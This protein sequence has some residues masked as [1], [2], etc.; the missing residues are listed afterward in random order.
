[1]SKPDP[2]KNPTAYAASLVVAAVDRDTAS[3][4]E[5]AQV[6]TERDQLLIACKAALA[7]LQSPE[8]QQ[9]IPPPI[10]ILDAAIRNAEGETP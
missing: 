7:Y 5:L 4:Y 6:Q 8:L 2:F 3:H 10:P 9:T 1:M